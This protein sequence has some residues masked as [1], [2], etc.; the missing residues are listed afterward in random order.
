MRIAV[1][2]DGAGIPAE[3][4]AQALRRFG[5]LDPARHVAGFGLS[6]SLVEG[7]TMA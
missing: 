7:G 1:A 6:L 2:D 3:G 5:R 4:H